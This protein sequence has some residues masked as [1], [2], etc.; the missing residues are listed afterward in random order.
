MEQANFSELRE[1]INAWDIQAEDLLIQKMKVFTIKYNEEFQNLCKN[2]DNFS[3]LISSTEVEHLKAI[4]QL[5]NLSSERFIEQTLDNKEDIPQENPQEEN[6]LIDRIEKM[7][8]SLEISMQCI[9][10]IAK[11]NKKEVIDDD[12]VSQQSSKIT[13][14]KNTKGI[15][16]PFIIGTEE[17]FADKTVGLVIAQQNEEEEN[18]DDED[19]DPDVEEMVSDI[20]VTEK[21][22]KNWEK[23]E[24]KRKAKKE[25]EKR[26]QTKVEKTQ[27]K[28]ESEVKVP[29][30]NEEDEKLKLEIEIEKENSNEIKVESKSG[31]SVPPPPPPPPPPPVLTAPVKAPPKVVPPPKPVVQ[32]PPPN[33]E[34]ADRNNVVPQN[35]ENINNRVI[36]PPRPKPVVVEPMSFEEQLRSRM[37]MRGNNN[38]ANKNPVVSPIQTI[39]DNQNPLAPV[40]R[41]KNIVINKQNVKLNNFMGGNLDDDDDE[42]DIDIKNSIFRR[43]QNNQN[44][45]QNKTPNLF[46]DN[47]K[48]PEPNLS[49]NQNNQIESQE[50]KMLS[51][52]QFIQIK[53][54]ENLVNAGKK[55]KKNIFDSDEEDD[56]A[57]KNIVD[58]TKDLTAKLNNFGVTQ[59]T[60]GQK[61]EETKPKPKKTFFDDDEDE[62]IKPKK[63]NNN[64]QQKPNLAFFNDDDDENKPKEESKPEPE[65][66]TPGSFMDGLKGILAQRNEKLN[67]KN[68]EP[69]KEEIKV[70]EPKKEEIKGEEPK[71]EEPKTEESKKEEPKVEEPKKEDPK[72]EEIK[73]EESERKNSGVNIQ[74]TLAMKNRNS[75][76]L[77]GK[78][79]D[80]QNMLANK[81]GK[82]MVMGDPKPPEKEEEKI[83]HNP[84]ADKGEPNYVEVVRSNT[85]KVVRKKKP[86]RGGAFE[87]G[88]EFIP[89][90]QKPKIEEPKKEVIDVSDK[91]DQASPPKA[92][93]GPAKDPETFKTNN[94]LQ[95]D[96]NKPNLFNFNNGKEEVQ[97]SI[98]LDN[99]D[100]K[101]A[102][103]NNNVITNGFK[104]D[105]TGKKKLAF[106]DDDDD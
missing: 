21:D 30:E 65:S 68:Q 22:R 35:P 53:T 98:F 57:Q 51:E 45:T 47:P 66:K 18:E 100:L 36:E 61:K 52:S 94:N 59:D 78:F 76:R 95:E 41:D 8:K 40:I 49:D 2:F 64:Q 70:E 48:P 28:E 73:K 97:K 72:K 42:D 39:A 38:N 10:S 19:N 93:E 75:A 74:K 9:D 82:G 101:K 105:E 96:N 15:K 79:S 80:M 4:N 50:K 55:M 26:K 103:E 91:K 1:K 71:K 25:K 14:E 86:K 77:N 84:S 34:Q 63:D 20:R 92:T 16:L 69:K 24:K 33:K 102:G 88:K 58:K 106:F 83:E 62:D 7:K 43:N 37:G 29:I 87:T 89:A 90:P 13:M 99:D 23:A 81:L 12:A 27:L 44:G 5:K 31:G 104:K 6:V 17:F 54:N 32:N 11:K 56:D 3:N 60:Q 67:K 46:S 85:T